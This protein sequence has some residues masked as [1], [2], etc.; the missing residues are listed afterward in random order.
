M[1]QDKYKESADRAADE[2]LEAI[3]N[4][5]DGEP[6]VK[7]AAPAEKPAQKP[8]EK[9]A[10]RPA[11]RRPASG[12]R[13]PAS[14]ER[15]PAASGERRP[16]ASG[17]RR[18]AASGERRPAASGERRPAAS[19]ERRPA[20]S[21]ERRPARTPEER[22]R[23]A[24]RQRPEI[25]SVDGAAPRRKTRPADETPR[26]SRP[27]DGTKRRRPANAPATRSSAKHAAETDTAAV[28]KRK[29]S[30]FRIGLLIYI[31]VF[32]LLMTFGLFKFR[33][34]LAEVESSLPQHTIENYVQHLDSNFYNEMV[35]QKVDQIPVTQYETADTI[36]ET[37]NLGAEQS[38][39]YTFA[40]KGDEFTDEKPVYYIRSGEAAIAKVTLSKAGETPSFAS[41]PSSLL[42]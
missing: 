13:R 40:K 15:R 39:G 41:S 26:R 25:E 6:E 16:A 11:R 20:A 36:A 37:L 8:A 4:E 24:Q 29:P 32:L 7:T 33:T 38:E 27:A 2:A 3:L 35:R 34:F 14:G 22:T 21:G 30:M 31:V 5:I 9:P 12:E 10:E 17:E 18:P 23:S 28:G 42:I 1:D 19:G